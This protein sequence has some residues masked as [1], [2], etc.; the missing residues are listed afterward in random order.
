MEV[1]EGER[2]RDRTRRGRRKG[3]MEGGDI[4]LVYNI[5]IKSTSSNRDKIE[6][7][8]GPLIKL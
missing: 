5:I 8:S 3:V 2:E 1:G 7:V 4:V 6:L